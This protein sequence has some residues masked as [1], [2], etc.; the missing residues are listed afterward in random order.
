[1]VLAAALHA[2]W[3]HVQLAA[4]DAARVAEVRHASLQ[5]GS[6]A[7]TVQVQPP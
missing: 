3:P 7:V 6:F 4:P 2:A 1:L 5:N